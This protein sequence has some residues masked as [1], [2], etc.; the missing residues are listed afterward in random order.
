MIRSSKKFQFDEL[1]KQMVYT[2]LLPRGIT[3]KNVLNVMQKIPRHLFVPEEYIGE[4]Y[5]DHPLPIGEGQTISQPYMVALMTEL[6]EPNKDKKI[7]EIGTGS[8]YQTAIL[9]ELSKEVYT[10]ERI[11]LLS[12][13]AQKLL[14]SLG[15]ENIYFKIADGTLGWAEYALFDGILVTAA[16]IELPKCYVEQ[17][18]EG[19]IIVIPLGGAFG[20]IL[21][22]FKKVKGEL[23]KKEICECVFVPLIGK[24]GF[25]E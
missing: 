19:G 22:V 11:G 20:Q 2:Q 6:L 17:I 8:G 3:D 9:A 5:D 25:K 7:L 10:I 15:Y 4:A 13:K 1:A 14:K 18:N 23:V 21:T 16:A 12:M 24:Y